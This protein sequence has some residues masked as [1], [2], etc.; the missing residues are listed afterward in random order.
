MPPCIPNTGL[1]VS[2]QFL[3]KFSGGWGI[4]G[5]R[6]LAEVS[7]KVSG[8][9]KLTSKTKNKN[10]LNLSYENYEFCLGDSWKVLGGILPL[11][12]STERAGNTYK[13]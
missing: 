2:G 6:V 3:A 10:G 7:L 1:V 9:K 8:G 5:G 4:L 11:Q 13:K 12:L